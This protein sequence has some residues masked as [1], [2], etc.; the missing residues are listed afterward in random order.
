LKLPERAG[1]PGVDGKERDFERRLFA[2]TRE[3]A[4][5]LYRLTAEYVERGRDY[6]HAQWLCP[7]NSSFGFLS[8]CS[9]ALL[10]YG[11]MQNGVIQGCAPQKNSF[12]FSVSSFQL[13]II[14]GRC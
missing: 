9:F 12:Q 13:F 5:S 11:A 3:Q 10:D 2:Q 1:Q 8:A 6:E 4:G 14:S 7:R